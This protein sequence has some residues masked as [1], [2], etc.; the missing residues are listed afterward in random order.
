MLDIEQIAHDMAKAGAMLLEQRIREA[1][2]HAG[3][4][5]SEMLQAVQHES[6]L[7]TDAHPDCFGSGV[8]IIW[9]K[10]RRRV[11]VEIC[12]CVEVRVVR[13]ISTGIV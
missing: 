3:V 13:R 7:I 9:S 6:R 5:P 10:D 1:L 8:R 12:G 4:P 11:H 2:R